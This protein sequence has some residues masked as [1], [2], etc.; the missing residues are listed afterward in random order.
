M[1]RE[2]L[3]QGGRPAA[4]EARFDVSDI[5]VETHLWYGGGVESV[6]APIGNWLADRIPNSVFHMP[7]GARAFHLEGFGQRSRGYLP[8]SA[9]QPLKLRRSS[10]RQL[11][12]ARRS[13]ACRSGRLDRIGRLARDLQSPERVATVDRTRD[14]SHG[15]WPHPCLRFQLNVDRRPGRGPNRKT[16]TTARHG[17]IRLPE[18][19]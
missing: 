16:R 3:K 6:P 14:V 9:V 12:L 2:S 8:G 5:K 10:G 11:C 15:R 4:H 17:H 1:M 13:H 19:R 18:D 7:A